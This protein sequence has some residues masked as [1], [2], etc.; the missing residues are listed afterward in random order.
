M[1]L[2]IPVDDAFCLCVDLAEKSV[3]LPEALSH[4]SYIEAADVHRVLSPY[5]YSVGL[6]MLGCLFC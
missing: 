1:L 2:I 4:F 3:R 5:F 6:Y